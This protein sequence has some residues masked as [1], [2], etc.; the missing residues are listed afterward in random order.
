MTT[1]LNTNA[2]RLLVPLMMA[3]VPVCAFGASPLRPAATEDR[4]P[5]MGATET[6][7]AEATAV[8]PG[9][10]GQIYATAERNASIAGSRV[11]ETARTMM[12][13]RDLVIGSCWDYANAVFKRAAHPNKRGLRKRVFSGSRKKRRFANVSLI[14]PGDW[15]YYVNHS[16][17]DVPHSAIFVAWLD[18][19]KKHALMITYRGA[20]RRVPGVLDDYNLKSVFRIVRP[21]LR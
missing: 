10:Y 21:T 17:S 7:Q 18:R 3:L 1:P 2:R 6:I 4:S 8:L 5:R 15:L 13:D 19:R 20:K 14:R 9:R 16:Y 12:V 11:L